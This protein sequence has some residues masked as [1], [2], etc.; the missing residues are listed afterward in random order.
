MDTDEHHPRPV[1][2][3]AAV[4]WWLGRGVGCALVVAVAGLVWTIAW[5]VATESDTVTIAAPTVRDTAD[6]GWAPVASRTEPTPRAEVVQDTADPAATDAAGR[7][8]LG[9]DAV[10]L[11]EPPPEAVQVEA[12]RQ[13]QQAQ[14]RRA[15]RADRQLAEFIEAA[16]VLE[17]L[18]AWVAPISGDYRITATFGQAGS[19]WANDHTGVDL[20]AP[21]G[22]AVAAVAA[23]TVTFA[24]D[25]GAYGTRVQVLH[26]DGTETSYS[27]MSRLDVIEGQVI[28]QGTVIGAVGTTGNSTGPHLHLELVPAG[29]DPVDPVAA[30][31]ARGVVL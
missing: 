18:D 16:G 15:L 4:P 26:A 23:G 19:L 10:P 27:H 8:N 2:R 20:A 17:R 31:L 21:S 11:V 6:A 12:R 28:E 24:G 3:S 29:G 14:K 25:A 13:R 22:T 9:T 5:G 1:T 7:G 30:L